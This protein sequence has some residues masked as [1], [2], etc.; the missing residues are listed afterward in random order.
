MVV[1]NFLIQMVNRSSFR[2]GSLSVTAERG[3]SVEKGMEKPTGIPDRES[4]CQLRLGI[5][6]QKNPV[7]DM[8]R[9]G[10]R[11]DL[12]ERPATE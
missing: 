9:Q 11:V 1:D 6:N 10:R 3:S 2:P 8:K 4:E 5:S 12:K 7:N